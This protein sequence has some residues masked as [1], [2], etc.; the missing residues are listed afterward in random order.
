MMPKKTNH[1]GKD[2]LAAEL[3]RRGG[4][5]GGKARAAGLSPEQRQEIS[6]LAALARWRRARGGEGEAAAARL[7][8]TPIASHRAAFSV[9]EHRL[10]GFLLED[11]RHLI[12][13]L[14]AATLLTNG[15]T[16][17]VE[18]LL[19]DAPAGE[20]VVAFQ[21]GDWRV[22]RGIEALAFVALCRHLAEPL[23]Q[24]LPACNPPA[25][26]RAAARVLALLADDGIRRAMEPVGERPRARARPRSRLTPE[27]A[28]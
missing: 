7:A 16:D 22:W 5:K 21:G 19:A 17:L 9:G 12:G 25:H 14:S 24:G 2:P 4:R 27:P 20:R 26:A 10:E 6:R 18:Q 15:D 1:A 23:W 11:G 3:G 13:L 8:R 28:A